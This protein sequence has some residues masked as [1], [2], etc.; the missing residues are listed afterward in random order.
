MYTFLTHYTS[1]LSPGYNVWMSASLLT[2]TGRGK[3]TW[4][5]RQLRSI[6]KSYVLDHIAPPTNPY[7][8]WSSSC[9]EDPN[10]ANEIHEHWQIHACSG[11]YDVVWYC[12]NIFLKQWAEMEEFMH[13]WDPDEMDGT[14]SPQ[15]K[16]CVWFHDESTFYANDR[17]MA[18][19]VHKD[20]TATPYTK[21]KGA[22]LMVSDFVSVDHGWLHFPD[23]KESAR[24][25][26]K[27]GKARDGYFTSDDIV[28]QAQKAIKLVKE[29]FPDKDH[30]LIFENVTT[31]LKR[32]DTALSACKMPKHPSKEGRNWGIEVTEK[33]TAG[34]IVLDGS[35]QSLYFPN[36]HPQHGYCD[37]LHVRAECPGFI[38]DPMV[39]HC[40]C[41]RM[42]YNEPDFVNV[43]STL[44]LACA[45]EGV[46]V[47]FLPKFHCELNFIEQCWGHTKQTYH[48][49][50][51]S[52][53]EE[54][55]ER[56]VVDA[57]Q[58]VTLDHMRKYACWA[59]HFMNTYRMGLT[60]RQAAW[61]SKKYQGHRVLPNLILDELEKANIS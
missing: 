51:A 8:M 11:H 50:P 58:S 33:D 61:A 23:G 16:I 46:C 13:T 9:L 45:L 49:Y 7:V 60:G 4:W 34:K 12:Q 54:D 44:E 10:I 48:Q 24:V 32:L 39:E 28:A 17:R 18:Q 20:T 43:K 26:F 55:L 57:L 42:L 37:M 29:Y 47:L 2:A 38:C 40:C 25:L 3:P 41:R 30:V 1:V 27:A 36:G 22:S 59:R 53:K 31:H 6:T 21:Y 56:N 5:A 52:S 15:Q 14:S 19:W 35:P